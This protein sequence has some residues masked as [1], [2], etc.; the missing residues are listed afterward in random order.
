MYPC[1]TAFIKRN[2]YTFSESQ[3]LKK[4][5]RKKKKEEEINVLPRLLNIL[6][7]RNNFFHFF[8]CYSYTRK[9]NN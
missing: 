5:K 6:F 7:N 2:T 8:H 3:T 9:L 1:H 4:K